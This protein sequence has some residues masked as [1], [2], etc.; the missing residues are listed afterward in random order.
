MQFIQIIMVGGIMFFVIKVKLYLDSE[1]NNLA[2]LF[3]ELL[4]EH[5]HRIN[6][7]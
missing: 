6:L 3:L 2:Q 5:P 1:G 7:V 4:C